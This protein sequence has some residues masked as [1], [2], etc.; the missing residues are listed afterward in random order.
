MMIKSSITSHCYFENFQSLA[1]DKLVASRVTN[2]VHNLVVKMLYPFMIRNSFSLFVWHK[3]KWPTSSHYLA[4]HLTLQRRHN[5]RDGVSNHRRLDHL[6][7]RLCR[8]RAKKTS[9]LRV[10]GL[11]EGNS[12][13][14]GEFAA[15]RASKAENVSIG[16][17]HHEILLLYCSEASQ[18]VNVWGLVSVI[19]F[20]LLILSIGVYASW[21]NKSLKSTKSEDI[22]LAKRDIGMGLG[23]FTMTGKFWPP[24]RLEL[25]FRQVLFKLAFVIDGGDIA[26]E[27]AIAWMSLSLPGDKSILFRIMASCLQIIR[28]YLNQSWPWSMSPYGITKPQSINV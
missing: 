6:L 8:R 7:N 5:E 25:N 1:Q 27:I 2:H 19:L 20:Y 13:V 24:G 22:M 3:L 17:R 4:K 26:C 16:W 11:C 15:Q 23:I 18:G 28:H 21:K 10:T 14:A 9:Q 12:P